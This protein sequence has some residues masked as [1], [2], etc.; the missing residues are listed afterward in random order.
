MNDAGRSERDIAGGQLFGLVADLDHSGTL[1][2]DVQFVLALVRVRCVFLARLEGVQACEERI[3]AR[4]G[5]FAHLVGREPGE[6]GGA[7]KE[8][9]YFAGAGAGAGAKFAGSGQ[10]PS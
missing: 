3:A 7:A 1:Q 8:H 6:T 9:R 4:D 10:F 2:D 5:A